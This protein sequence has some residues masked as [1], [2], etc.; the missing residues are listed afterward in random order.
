MGATPISISSVVEWLTVRSLINVNWNISTY[1]SWYWWVY[2]DV[3]F[4]TLALEITP[5]Y[6]QPDEQESLQSTMNESFSNKPWLLR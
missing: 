2:T 3:C 1:M 4:S 6:L 5:D